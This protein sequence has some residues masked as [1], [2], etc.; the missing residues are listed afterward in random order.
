METQ[1]NELDDIRRK[2]ANDLA[3]EEYRKQNMRS[4]VYNAAINK[5][6]KGNSI[7]ITTEMRELGLE[8]DINVAAYNFGLNKRILDKLNDEDD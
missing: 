5:L 3:A 7:V 8:F 1:Y 6:M 4:D 2:L